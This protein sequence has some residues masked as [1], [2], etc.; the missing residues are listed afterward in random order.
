MV[1]FYTI[2]KDK[3]TKVVILLLESLFVLHVVK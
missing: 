1:V 3:E 2:N